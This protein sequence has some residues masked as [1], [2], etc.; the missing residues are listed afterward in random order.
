MQPQTVPVTF[1]DPGILAVALFLSLVVNRI[2]AYFATPIFEARKWD[3]R[4]LMYVS[5]LV[6]LLLSWAANLNLLPGLFPNPLVGMIVTAVIVG[7]GANLIHD[8]IDSIG[9]AFGGTLLTGKVSVERGAVQADTLTFEQ[10][11]QEA[12]ITPVTV[13][14]GINSPIL[15]K[16]P[17]DPTPPSTGGD[18]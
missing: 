2:V 15:T 7:G 12:P 17:P 8:I 3:K 5:A 18:V 13:A 11:T 4:W 1:F 6:G 16:Y 9:G 10:P 14:S